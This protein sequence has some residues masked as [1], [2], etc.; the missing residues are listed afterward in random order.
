MV[1][2]AKMI[3]IGDMDG[4]DVFENSRLVRNYLG[5]GVFLRRSRTGS[6]GPFLTFFLVRLLPFFPSE[7]TSMAKTVSDICKDL[8]SRFDSYQGPSF[9]TQDSY[10]IYQVDNLSF[11]HPLSAF[12]PFT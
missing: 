3:L 5:V 6:Q 2:I 1:E 9:A 8:N 12:L 11:S 7:S 4:H 10:K